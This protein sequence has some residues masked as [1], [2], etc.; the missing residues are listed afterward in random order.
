MAQF[1]WSLGEDLGSGRTAGCSPLGVWTLDTKNCH[2]LNS[3]HGGE[4]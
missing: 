2:V 3:Y 1:H 4:Y